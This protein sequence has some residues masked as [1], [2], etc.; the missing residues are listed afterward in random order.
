MGAN[1]MMESYKLSGCSR[2][3]VGENTLFMNAVSGGK[4]ASGQNFSAS[5]NGK[6]A[7][8]ATPRRK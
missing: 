8:D 2:C 3:V 7:G 4:L 1:G 6:K 5:R